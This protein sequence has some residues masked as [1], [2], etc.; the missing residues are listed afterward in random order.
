V[1]ARWAP[2]PPLPQS[3]ASPRQPYPASHSSLHHRNSP[4]PTR[5][6]DGKAWK[7][8][9][10]IQVQRVEVDP[11]IQV[12]RVEVDP[13]IQATDPTDPT[14]LEGKG[15]VSKGKAKG[16]AKAKGKSKSKSK[17]E[18]KSKSKSDPP[19]QPAAPPPPADGI[20]DG[21]ATPVTSLVPTPVTPSRRKASKWSLLRA[22]VGIKAKKGTGEKGGKGV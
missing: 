19:P 20:A 21:D 13:N 22:G 14:D 3:L 7:V 11:N 6:F 10:N 15:T 8:D 12:Q 16:K 2:P 17:S 18:S 1:R 4:H 9:P 5:Y